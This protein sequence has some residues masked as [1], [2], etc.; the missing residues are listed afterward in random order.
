MSQKDIILISPKANK[1]NLF[2]AF[3]PVSVPVGV[4]ALAGYLTMKGRKVGIID[5]ALA[6]LSEENVHERVGTPPRI[7]GI[8]SM[9]ANIGRA[10]RIASIVKNRYPGTTIVF[11][12]IHPTVLPE[13][14][15][16]NENID[17]VVRGEG[18]ITLDTLCS[19]ILNAEDFRTLPGISFKDNGKIVHNPPGGVIE[20]LD[21]LPQFPYH[22]F[23]RERYDLGFIVSSRGC[24][25]D[26]IYCSQRAI[27]GRRYRY[28]SDE[29]VI[30]ELH[31]LID[32]FHQKAI[33]FMDDLFTVNKNRV[34]HLCKNLIESGLNKKCVFSVQ[35]RGDTVDEEMLKIMKEAGFGCLIIGLE[36]A[37][38]RL[39]KIIE[40][41]ET[42][43]DNVETVKLAKKYGFTINAT[44]IFGLPTEE[45]KDRQDAYELAKELDVDRI[46]FNNAVP[47][48]GTKLFEIA[49]KENRMYIEKDWENFNS[50]GVLVAKNVKEY[51][52][53]YIPTTTTKEELIRDIIKAN[54]FYYLR[55]KHLVN[56]F[57][58]SKKG[59]GKWFELPEG[60]YLKPKLILGLASLVLFNV[61]RTIEIL[62]FMPQRGK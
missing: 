42:V 48:P 34:L 27:S 57:S 56:L 60:F 28:R 10:Y 26:C 20:D 38:D 5:E 46:R 22:L 50:V 9:T 30:N 36:T 21:M 49:K 44:F 52:L 32:E 45:S 39:M 51:N 40:K 55:W 29:K 17:V 7:F 1:L 25:Y 8:S 59:G 61:I 31:L 41:K 23:E 3:V 33:L 6:P 53:P 12:G 35:T 24:P 62:F 11:G 43:R 54:T 37:S 18:E 2:E 13:E 19:K 14:V 47:Y 4:G 15:L 58:G 16:Q